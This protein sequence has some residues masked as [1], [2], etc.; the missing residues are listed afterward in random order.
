M[1]YAITSE[2][3]IAIC[4]LLADFD[5][6]MGIGDVIRRAE[7]YQECE[8]GNFGESE[9]DF[10]K[11]FF[12]F[13]DRW[14]KWEDAIPRGPW[15]LSDVPLK[16]WITPLLTHY[17]DIYFNDEGEHWTALP[18]ERKRPNVSEL[19]WCQRK[20]QKLK[21]V[22]GQRRQ[23]MQKFFSDPANFQTEKIS[24][25]LCLLGWRKELLSYYLFPRMIYKGKG[26][27]LEWGC[28]NTI[29]WRYV[30]EDSVTDNDLKIISN[31]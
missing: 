4:L 16:K 23:L 14:I 29:R 18:E 12:W 13:G 26:V 24:E 30:L 15:K 5:P 25:L 8:S 11:A 1:A 9:Y 6:E 27:P 7:E 21:D 17:Q 19:P 10:S 31:G 3:M 2:D 22:S 20:G 28:G